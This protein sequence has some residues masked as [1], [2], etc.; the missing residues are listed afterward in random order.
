MEN[1]SY[2]LVKGSLKIMKTSKGEQMVDWLKQHLEN[3]PPDELK[4]EWQEVEKEFSKETD[5]E[6][7]KIIWKNFDDLL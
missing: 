7:L 6:I 2:L 1:A 3:T 4:K 5:P